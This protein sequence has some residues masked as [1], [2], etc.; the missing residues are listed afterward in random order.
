MRHLLAAL[1]TA[2]FLASCDDGNDRVSV[3]YSGCGGFGTT[4]YN[5]LAVTENCDEELVWFHN[6]ATNVLTLTH[7]NTRFNCAFDD[8]GKISVTVTEK[9][10]A[11]TVEERG[12][13]DIWAMCDC[14]YDIEMSI[15]DVDPV[16]TTMTVQTSQ[17]YREEEPDLAWTGTLDLTQESGTILIYANPECY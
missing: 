17:S 13:S 10:D 9:G 11:Y 8:H 6:K 1:F 14:R 16:L 7:R 15:K 12:T 2:A 3:R 5:L 4:A